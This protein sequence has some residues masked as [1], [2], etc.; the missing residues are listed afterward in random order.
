MFRRMPIVDFSSN[1]RQTIHDMTAPWE[2]VEDGNGESEFPRAQ[3][4]EPEADIVEADE[5]ISQQ[6]PKRKKLG[7]KHR[8]SRDDIDISREPDSSPHEKPISPEANSPQSE[9]APTTARSP[10]EVPETNDAPVTD[11]G[12]W[13]SSDT[14]PKKKRKLNKKKK[15]PKQK[16]SHRASKSVAQDE[17]LEDEYEGEDYEALAY[18]APKKSIFKRLF[19]SSKEEQ[20]AAPPPDMYAFTKKERLWVIDGLLTFEIQIQN[21]TVVSVEK[22]RYATK[23]EAVA[24]IP[25]RRSKVIWATAGVRESKTEPITV[26]NRASHLHDAQTAETVFGDSVVAVRNGHMLFGITDPL[27]KQLAERHT[28]YLSAGACMPHREGYWLR[29]GDDMAE[30]ALIK[31][32]MMVEW[33]AWRGMGTRTARTRIEDEHEDPRI[34]LSEQVAQLSQSV[35]QLRSEWSM[36]DLSGGNIYLHGPGAG[37][38]G[39]ERSLRDHTSCRV[40]EPFVIDV[41]EGIVDTSQVTTAVLA[42]K[43]DPMYVTSRVIKQEKRRSRNKKLFPYSVVSLLAVAIMGWSWQEGNR[44]DKRLAEANSRVSNAWYLEDLEGKE[45]SDKGVLAQNL[46]DDLETPDTYAWENLI[47][48]KYRRNAENSTGDGPVGVE[49]YRCEDL[50]VGDSVVETYTGIE[51]AEASMQ[52]LAEDIFGPGATIENLSDLSSFKFD[53]DGSSEVSYTLYPGGDCLVGEAEE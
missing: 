30:M 31:N 26:T 14:K 35:T 44:T 8:K 52:A 34:V 4:S 49:V 47:E 22:T 1:I 37:W 11:N 28:L 29:V 6:P 36:R 13:S 24:S 16:K 20:D 50:D 5:E 45:L 2:Q 46:L 19:K 21:N 48:Y 53:L 9:D 38:T 32:G 18:D 17:L 39:V 27:A 15:H 40:I 7:R 43:T 42:L 33:G 23:E 25:K 3:V 12:D 41:N 10:W 51:G